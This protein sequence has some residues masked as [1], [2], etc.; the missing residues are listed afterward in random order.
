ME[1]AVW[2][3]M[4]VISAVFGILIIA[5]IVLDSQE[6]VKLQEVKN[7]IERINQLCN[8]VCDSDDGT[9]LSEK[10][11]L[12]S[13]ASVSARVSTKA[14]CI[15]Y[16]GSS[17]CASCKCGLNKDYDLNLATPEHVFAFNISDYR[18]FFDKNFGRVS[19]ECKG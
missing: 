13:G 15:T 12:P 19:F 14:V 7:S 11:K 6:Q 8:F 5:T 18:C 3:Y 9:L 2:L 1:Q 16:S 17:K 10:L 4:G